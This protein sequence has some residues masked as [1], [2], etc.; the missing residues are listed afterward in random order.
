[1]LISDKLRFGMCESMFSLDII[2]SVHIWLD[3]VIDMPMI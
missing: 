3:G 2:F 1:M